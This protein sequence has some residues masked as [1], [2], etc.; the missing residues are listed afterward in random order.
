LIKTKKLVRHVL[1]AGCPL[2]PWRS[3]ALGTKGTDSGGDP[4]HSPSPLDSEKGVCLLAGIY[5]SAICLRDLGDRETPHPS[6]DALIVVPS[7][8]L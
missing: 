7:D 2:L 5:R 3:I 4:S 1:D 8:E 6:F